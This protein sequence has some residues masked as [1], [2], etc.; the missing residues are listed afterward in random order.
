MKMMWVLASFAEADLAAKE[1]DRV[2]EL[3]GQ[4]TAVQTAKWVRISGTGFDYAAI[5]SGSEARLTSLL[6]Y[7]LRANLASLAR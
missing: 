3:T 5:D 1:A 6:K 2:S 7:Q 4:I